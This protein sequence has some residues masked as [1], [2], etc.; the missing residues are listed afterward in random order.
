MRE[1]TD[2]TESLL[3]KGLDLTV[4]TVSNVK[5]TFSNT[6]RTVVLTKSATSITK[7]GDDT[8][9]VV[10]LTQSE[11]SM[12]QPNKPCDI[13]INWLDNGKR[14]GTDI[15]TIPVF[16]NLLKEVWTVE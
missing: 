8:V 6:L 11:T 16:E 1:F 2:V 9:V 4:G 14:R 12:F 5:V 15:V 13:I 10:D 3:V 7:S